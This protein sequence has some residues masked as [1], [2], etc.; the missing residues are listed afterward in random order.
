[1]PDLA[2]QKPH[3]LYSLICRN[4]LTHGENLTYYGII[5]YF[6]VKEFPSNLP[7]LYLCFAFERGIESATL[8]IDF[9]FPETNNM[10]ITWRCVIPELEK[11]NLFCSMSQSL[12]FPLSRVESPLRVDCVFFLDGQPIHV[13][14][15]WI[16]QFAKPGDFLR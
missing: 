7:D 10:A 6:T 4:R 1:M 9:T 12:K 11:L 16:G 5:H 8:G 14:P 15:F 2:S 3:L 13:H